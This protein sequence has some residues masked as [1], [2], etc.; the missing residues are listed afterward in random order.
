MSKRH[1]M[2][3]CVCVSHFKFCESSRIFIKY[4]RI[5]TTEHHKN[6]GNSHVPVSV[7]TIWRTCEIV[8]WKR[9][10]CPLLFRR[11]TMLLDLEELPKI[12]NVKWFCRL[13]GNK[14]N[15]VTIFF[16][17]GVQNSVGKLIIIIQS[18]HKM[19]FLSKI[20]DTR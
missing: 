7:T 16:R 6:A 3:V 4:L 5:C 14:G 18:L 17:L 2:C 10:Y 13:R 8:R 19:L 9:H 11:G 20:F 1:Y 15:W 12:I